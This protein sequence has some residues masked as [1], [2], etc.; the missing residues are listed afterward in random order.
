MSRQAFI[1][2]LAIATILVVIYFV[3]FAEA[4]ATPLAQDEGRVLFRW[5]IPTTLTSQTDAQL[6]NDDDRLGTHT[7]ATVANLA[8]HRRFPIASADLTTAAGVV[9][10]D[11]WTFAIPTTPPDGVC[12]IFLKYGE[13]DVDIALNYDSTYPE[14]AKPGGSGNRPWAGDYSYSFRYTHSGGTLDNISPRLAMYYRG[15]EPATIWWARPPTPYSFSFID[16]GGDGLTQTHTGRGVSRT[17]TFPA[18][19]YLEM[20]ERPCLP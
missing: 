3:M 16:N 20:R 6:Q 19:A 17:V 1:A 4:S 14:R 11:A 18:G 12:G 15:N 2:G 5:D 10:V 9:L 13:S 8:W 7:S